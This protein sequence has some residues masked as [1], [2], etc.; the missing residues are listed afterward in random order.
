M[1][2]NHIIYIPMKIL[3]LSD[4]KTENLKEVIRKLNPDLII[5]L[6]DF[7]Y[8]DL[9]GLEFIDIPKMGVYWNHC[10]RWYMETYSIQ[11]LHLNAREFHGFI[12]GWFEWCVRYKNGDYIMYT[13]E[14]AS[15]LLETFSKVDVFISHCPP[16]WINDNNDTAHEGFHALKTYIDTHSPKYLFHGHTYEDGNFITKYKNTEIVYI[17]R[18]KIIEI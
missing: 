3:A 6:W 5:T 14:E 9:M 11:D 13:Q 2:S 10:T 4:K 15:T 7:D 8:G 18:Y 1:P 17:D 12:F 16:F